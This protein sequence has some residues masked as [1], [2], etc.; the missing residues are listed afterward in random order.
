MVQLYNFNNVLTTP[1]PV[2]ISGS[3]IGLGSVVN[4]VQLYAQVIE[5]PVYVCGPTGTQLHSAAIRLKLNI[6]LVDAS[7][8]TSAL[9]LLP[10]VSGASVTVAQVELYVEVA[11]ANGI[12][13]AVDALANAVTVQATP[14]VAD[15][16][17][18]SISDSVF[19]NRSHV[20]SPATDLGYATIGTLTVNATT[21]NIQARSYARGQAPFA[22]A[23]TFGGPYPQT[24]TASTSAA[25]VANLV[26][27]LVANLDLSLSPSLGLLDATILPT[28]K[29]IVGGSLTPTLNTLMTGLVDPL[30]EL[31][32]IRLGEVDV[33]VLGIALS[34]PVS[35]TV[36]GD[37]NHNSRMDSGE[38]G[39]G[40]TL[41]AKLVPASGPASQ[42][43]AVDPASGVYS[44]AAVAAASYSVIID[45]N[46]T[47][48]DVTA[49]AP[50]GWVGTESPNLSRTVTV[51][52]ADI[53][54]QNF[55]LYNGSRV[56]GAVFKDN[57]NGGGVANN[58]VLDGGEAGIAGAAVKATDTGGGTTYDSAATGAYG[59]Y[60]LWI[61]AAAGATQLK[62]IE[63]NLGGYV[64]T[65]GSAGNTGGSYD[66]PVDT[67]TFTNAIG[68]SYSGVNFADVPD[69]SFDTDGQQTALPGAV[70]FYP[71]TFTAGS[72]GQVSF[73]VTGNVASPGISGWNSVIY[74]DG[75]CNGILDSGENPLTAAVTV[76]AD[77]KICLL[78]KVFVPV[79]ALY[80]AQDKLTLSASFTYTNASPSLASAQART[81]FTTVGAA[82]DAGLKL[83]K[84]VDKS[85]AR[86][87]DMITYTIAYANTG[88]GALSSL[89]IH[90]TTPAYTTF[91]NAACGVLPTGLT[92]CTVSTK[93][94]AGSTGAIA[95]DFSGT[96][97]PGASGS[98]SFSVIL[99]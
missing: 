89:R 28:L 37:A 44:F 29:T 76:N 77:Q 26:D 80:N 52:N 21:V 86:S 5:P 94:A 50:A 53:T 59:A 85:T 55:G 40:L 68:S 92:V 19:F 18:G 82:T 30:L 25:F 66:R 69:N 56:S 24:R 2:T 20:L 23:L 1:S 31:L 73:G 12:I 95:W 41:Y 42:A 79:G 35:G 43:V 16:Y 33:T 47:L 58:G 54:A 67:V 9:N 74:Q 75:N 70:V 22:S 96:L 72:G 8:D 90:E 93:P 65:G 84:S 11:R 46:N 48:S 34:C 36:Y 15:L 60:V 13:S 83:T 49:T 98:V 10:G 3:A 6:D 45:T 64:S 4:S 63:T 32:G 57:G 14:G 71:H 62:I 78:V 99:E 81:D 87:G 38:S 97:A 51:T 17:L 7:P 61:P 88:S 39:T 27:A 91:N